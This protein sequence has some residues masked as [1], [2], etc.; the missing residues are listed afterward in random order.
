MKGLG[1]KYGASAVTRLTDMGIKPF[2][3]SS[4]LLG[5]L[6]AALTSGM[7]LMRSDGERL[8]QAVAG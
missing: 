4:S 2:L 1:L 7:T 8:V 5:V 3:M 6:A